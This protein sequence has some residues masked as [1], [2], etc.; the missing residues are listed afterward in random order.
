MEV[1]MNLMKSLLTIVLC[2]GLGAERPCVASYT[3]D[4]KY[5]RPSLLE[6]GRDGYIMGLVTGFFPILAPVTALSLAGCAAPG[7]SESEVAVFTGSL[8]AGFATGIGV[9]LAAIAFCVQQLSDS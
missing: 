8:T 3:Q 1:P 7:I 5:Q 9:W 2:A 6:V 4:H